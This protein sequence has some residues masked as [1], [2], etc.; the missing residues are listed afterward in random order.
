MFDSKKS[1]DSIQMASV[2]ESVE[3][4]PN[5]ND[6]KPNYWLESWLHKQQRTLSKLLSSRNILRNIYV[7]LYLVTD[8]V[9]YFSDIIFFSVQMKNLCYHLP[10]TT[11]IYSLL[12]IQPTV[13]TDVAT[14]G[15]N[16]IWNP[17]KVFP[18]VWSFT[19]CWEDHWHFHSIKLNFV[20]ICHYF[21][22]IHDAAIT[23]R[24]RALC[25]CLWLSDLWIEKSFEGLSVKT[26]QC[27]DPFNFLFSLF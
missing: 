19:Q 11:L 2:I 22:Y 6:W 3:W 7:L 12:C 25:C 14:I 4:I 15:G 21:T 24:V 10:L 23:V 1:I 8:I 17:K 20:D 5:M 18:L 27:Q 16:K 9:S 26:S 13:N